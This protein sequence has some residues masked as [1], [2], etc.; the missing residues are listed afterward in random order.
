[1]QTQFFVW[2]D[3]TRA[4]FY[5]PDINSANSPNLTDQES[6][7]WRGNY[8]VGK[9]VPIFV[10]TSPQQIQKLLLEQIM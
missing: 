10:V 4:N 7:P 8:R 3:V 1:M 2:V 9:E 5:I 6:L